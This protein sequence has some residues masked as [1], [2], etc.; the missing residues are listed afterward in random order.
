ML[1]N[2]RELARNWAVGKDGTIQVASATCFS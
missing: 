1:V 2:I